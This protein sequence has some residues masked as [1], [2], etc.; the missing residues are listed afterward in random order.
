MMH[1]LDAIGD[2]ELRETLLFTRAQALPVT[3]DEVA[4]AQGIHRNVARG[5][6]ERLAEAGLLIASFE[7]RTGRTGPGA[8]R[9]PRPIE[10]HRS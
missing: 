2:R 9:R 4:A 10:S 7:R 1:R 6:L 5:R 8:G 3:A